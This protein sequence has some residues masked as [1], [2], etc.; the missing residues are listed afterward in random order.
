MKRKTWF[1]A[2]VG[3]LAMGSSG[4]AG[5]YHSNLT[6]AELQAE[7]WQWATSIPASHNPIFDKTGN[8]CGMGQRAD[9][10]FLAGSTGGRVTRNCTVPAG[11]NL[12]VPVVNTMCYPDAVDSEASCIA[13]SDDFIDSFDSGTILL[14]VDGTEVDTDDVGSGDDFSFTVD[15]NGIFGLKPGVY[16]ATYAR[17]Y[18]GVVPALDEGHHTIHM[19]ASGPLFSLDVTYHLEVVAPTN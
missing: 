2:L 12:L 8:R 19:V 3:M 7:W 17:G 9:L 10:W 11:V 4:V 14:E 1:P 5:A 6:L 18:W 13:D 15:A 16:R